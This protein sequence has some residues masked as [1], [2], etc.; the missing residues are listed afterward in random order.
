MGRWPHTQLCDVDREH[1][2]G[3]Y[4]DKI[5][6]VKLQLREDAEIAA[7]HNDDDADQRR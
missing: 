4:D 5:A 7:R 1:G 6:E 3:Q 2:H